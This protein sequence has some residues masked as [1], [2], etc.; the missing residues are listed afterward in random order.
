MQRSG[1]G[2]HFALPALLS[3]IAGPAL[4]EPQPVLDTPP[5]L[6]EAFFRAASVMQE[7]GLPGE[8]VVTDVAGPELSA[9]FGLADRAARTPNEVGQL[10]VWASVTKQVTATL[11]MQE[12][13][14]GRIHSMHP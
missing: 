7:A 8:I 3:A 12:V 2:K 13:D 5:P 9:A 4:A 11:V 1:F 10:C 14:R 6:D